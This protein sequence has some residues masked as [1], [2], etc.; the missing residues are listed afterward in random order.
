MLSR[1]ISNL[2]FGFYKTNWTHHLERKYPNKPLQTIFSRWL[3]VSGDTVQVR[4]G[5]DRGKIGKVVK[6]LRKI[7]RVVIRG[8]NVNEYSKST[9]SLIQ[10]MS[11]GRRSDSNVHALSTSQTLD[12]M[13]RLL[14]NLLE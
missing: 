9:S 2:A 1:L 5:D 7:N 11:K 10:P 6:V 4:S 13:I 3:I 14:K 12:S 8:V